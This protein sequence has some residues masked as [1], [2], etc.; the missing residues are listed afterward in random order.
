MERKTVEE[1]DNSRPEH[2]EHQQSTEC[3]AWETLLADYDLHEPSHI[4][5]SILKAGGI[6]PSYRPQFWCHELLCTEQAT[7]NPDLYQSLLL[8]PIS[9]RN[10]KCIEIDLPRTYKKLNPERQKVLFRVLKAIAVFHPPIGYCQGMNFVT[11]MI[12]LA[13]LREEVSPLVLLSFWPSSSVLF[14]SRA[15][16]LPFSTLSSSF[17]TSLLLASF[18]VTLIFFFFF[19]FFIFFFLFSSLPTNNIQNISIQKEAFWAFTSLNKRYAIGDLF[20]K[21]LPGLTKPLADLEKALSEHLPQLSKHFELEDLPPRMIGTK[22]FLALFGTCLPSTLALLVWDCL[23]FCGWD[24][25]L[26]AALA[27]LH[28]FHDTLLNQRFDEMLPFLG[29]NLYTLLKTDE[30]SQ[31]LF[32]LHFAH[33]INLFFLSKAT[34]ATHHNSHCAQQVHS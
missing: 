19:F 8:L 31:R 11:G 16:V 32:R 4:V 28:T 9:D 14:L 17:V 27:I 5:T 20:L 22:W 33:Y 25:V 26:A 34:T 13:G 23:L 7:K 29:T 2:D 24:A 12:L 30:C 3:I 15:N 18:V 21:G 10:K 6:E 1:N